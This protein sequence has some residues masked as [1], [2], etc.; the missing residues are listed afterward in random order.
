MLKYKGCLTPNYAQKWKSHPNTEMVDLPYAK[1]LWVYK[2][3]ER[4]RNVWMIKILF[5]IGII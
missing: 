3:G 5:A 1:V 2:H 4:E